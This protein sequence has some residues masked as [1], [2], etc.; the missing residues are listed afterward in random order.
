MIS[1]GFFLI[2]ISMIIFAILNIIEN[3]IHYNI[4]TNAHL[5]EQSQF[6]KF[7]IPSTNDFI[8]ILFVMLIFGITQG[9]LTEIIVND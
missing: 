3:L 9:V 6:I 5:N 8:K 1:K 7:N 2:L 4:G